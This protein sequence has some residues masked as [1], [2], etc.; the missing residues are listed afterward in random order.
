MRRDKRLRYALSRGLSVREAG[1]PR[2]PICYRFPR[3]EERGWGVSCARAGRVRRR[4]TRSVC[5]V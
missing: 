2:E 4:T 5:N 3:M 1:Q